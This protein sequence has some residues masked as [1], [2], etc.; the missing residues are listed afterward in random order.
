M[1]ATVG[2]QTYLYSLD[3]PDGTQRRCRAC[4]R[5]TNRTHVAMPEGPEGSKL[6]LLYDSPMDRATLT[7]GDSASASENSLSAILSECGISHKDCARGDCCA[8]ETQERRRPTRLEVSACS[9]W[10]WLSLTQRFSPRVVLAIGATASCL[11]Y[12]ARTLSVAIQHSANA[13]YVPDLPWARQANL[14]VVPAPQA[15]SLAAQRR[16]FDGRTWT[17]IA[18][19]QVAIAASLLR[20]SD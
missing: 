8:C 17:S 20:E 5:A 3:D 10:L 4:G 1:N 6:F 2:F 18:K 19:D 9:H 7:S 15:E 14:R 12:E 16:S 11:F 13:K